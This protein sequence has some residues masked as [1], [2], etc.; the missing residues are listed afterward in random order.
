MLDDVLGS[1][2]TGLDAAVWTR[3]WVGSRW[4]PSFTTGD[5]PELSRVYEEATQSLARDP[6]DVQ[7]YFRRGVVCQSKG[8][9]PQ[10]VADFR[11]VLRRDGRHARAWLLLSE[12]LTSLGEY[13]QAKVAREQ[14]RALDPDLQ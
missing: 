1:F 7:A 3:W 8:W 12:V 9:Y 5:P 4:A 14:V 11:E 6:S 13:E 10:A 2:L